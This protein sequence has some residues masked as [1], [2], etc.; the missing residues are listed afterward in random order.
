[1][2]IGIKGVG[3]REEGKMEG[4]SGRTGKENG[5]GNGMEGGAGAGGKG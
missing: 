3:T 2:G 5:N 1:M 4:R